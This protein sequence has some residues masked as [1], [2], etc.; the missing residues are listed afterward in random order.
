MKKQKTI[1]ATAKTTTNSVAEMFSAA[2]FAGVVNHYNNDL[3]DVPE[4]LPQAKIPVVAFY[5]FRGGTGRTTT[6]AH[7]AA[8]MASREIQVVAIDLDVEAPGLQYV[9]DCP[10]PE[11]G[12]GTVALLR[13]AAFLNSPS[14]LRL[15]PHVLKSGLDLGTPIRVL[16]AGCLSQKYLDQLDDLGVPL[17]HVAEESSPLQ[18]LIDKVKE[19]MHPQAIFLDCRTGLSGLSASAVFHIADVVVC[20]LPVSEQSLDGLDVFL[21]GVK[22]AKMK[23]LGRPEILMVPSMIPEGPES[24]RRL[25]EWF[26]PEIEA[27]YAKLVLGLKL[28]NNVSEAEIPVLQEGIEYRRGIALSDHLRSDFI[29]LSGGIYQPLVQ[30]LDSMIGLAQPMASI[31]MNVG[32]ILSELDQYGDL[33]KLAYAEDTKPEDIVKKFIQPSDFKAIVDRATWYVV[34][35]KGAGKTW[36]YLWL[37]S[38]AGDRLSNEMTYLSVHGPKD[39]DRLFTANALREIE[40]DKRARMKQR[41]LHGT[42]WLLYAAKRIL[43]KHP[44]LA[45]IVISNFR[46]DERFLIK[47]LVKA[48]DRN[49]HAEL[50]C[51]LKYDRIA[52]LAEDLLEALDREM[53]KQGMPAITLLYDGLDVGFGSDEKSIDMRKR[54]I[55][56]LVEAI[57]PLR[58]V[59]K[60]IFFKLFLREDIYEELDIQN[61]SHLAAATVELRWMPRDL[62]MLALNLVSS[63]PKYLK[64]IRSIEPSVGPENWPADEERRQR[65]LVP[66]WGEQLEGGNKISTAAFVQ[67]RTAD[68]KD[69]LFPR[70]LVQLL[71]AAV[72]H[73]QK[74]EFR[75]DRIL[76]SV[77]IQDGYRLASKKRVE[78]LRKEYEVLGRYLNSLQGMT[79][80]GTEKE[81]IDYL[82]RQTPGKLKT[83]KKGVAAGALHAGPGGWRKVINLL[84]SVG[85]LREYRR[86]RGESGE[87]KY[88]ISLLYRPGLGIKAFGV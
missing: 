18:I 86:A 37:R 72:K 6:L 38:P 12:R 61:Q 81:I 39:D 26:I 32:A 57:E 11:E 24:R 44:S 19:E 3:L 23:R 66:L 65:L 69:R 68:G 53:L 7:V 49:F 48:S 79:P 40:E 76:R 71:D 36:T 15:A 45:N 2:S 27:K 41:R 4:E 22:A 46:A 47:C 13:E 56:A 33:K 31:T 88:E 87:L 77:A 58:G 52:T 5:G 62:W 55:K 10:P 50:P 82:S 75:S 9:L 25:Q 28:S 74:T 8:I 14:E 42:L 35:A 73:Q 85:V 51:I 64:V 67:R 29:Q 34:G 60:R 84:L 59:N 63:S 78:D 80:T 17:W 21:K 83:G 54:F 16:P 20:V 70:T 43:T 30:Y 1:K